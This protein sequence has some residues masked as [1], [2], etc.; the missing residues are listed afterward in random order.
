MSFIK[1]PTNQKKKKKTKKTKQAKKV[2]NKSLPQG[3][4]NE[5]LKN[6]DTLK[7]LKLSCLFSFFAL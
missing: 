7:T 2:I 4:F 1:N 5:R 3:V 6:S